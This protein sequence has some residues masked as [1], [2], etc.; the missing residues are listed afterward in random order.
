[1]KLTLAA[2]LLFLPFI[3]PVVLQLV[4][5]IRSIKYKTRLKIWQ[6]TLINIGVM[7]VGTL[8]LDVFMM[9]PAITITHNGL[10]YIG[11][12]MLAIITLL[13]V[14]SIAIIQFIISRKR[15]RANVIIES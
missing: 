14:F 2:I 1:V 4:L 6:I 7:I 13:V 9:R 10:A 15:N 12:A 11:L 8:L 5:G 3:I